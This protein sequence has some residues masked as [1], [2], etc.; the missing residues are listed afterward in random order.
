MRISDLMLSFSDP[1][2]RMRQFVT[3]YNLSDGETRPSR[4]ATRLKRYYMARNY[5][6]NSVMKSLPTSM[7]DG[8]TVHNPMFWIGAASEKI[9]LHCEQEEQLLIV[10]DGSVSLRLFDPTER[11]N[12]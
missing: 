1:Y 12:L 8:F 2:A 3:S 10:V 11:E 5:L 6:P 7:L 9:R 4:A